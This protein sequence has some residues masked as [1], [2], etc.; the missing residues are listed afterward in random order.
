MYICIYIYIVSTQLLPPALPIFC[1]S[2]CSQERDCK[3]C[4]VATEYFFVA[5][6]CVCAYSEECDSKA[7]SIA[8]SVALWFPVGIHRQEGGDR[9]DEGAGELTYDDV[10]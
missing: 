4:S 7:C 2:A 5:F 1:F 9:D 10:S 8:T 3:V 6:L